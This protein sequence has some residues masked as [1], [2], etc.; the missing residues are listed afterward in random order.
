[1][2]PSNTPDNA[3]T[4]TLDRGKAKYFH[5]REAVLR[6]FMTLCDDAVKTNGGTTFLVDGAPGAGKSALLHECAARAGKEGWVVAQHMTTSAF[7]QA[8]SMRK[9]MHQLR[10][11]NIESG[12]LQ[13]W[14]AETSA[15]ST[16][17]EPI[18]VLG[19]G[20][21][22]LLLVL[23]EAQKLRFLA[24]SLPGRDGR[25][26]LDTIDLIHN[27]GLGRPV[28]LL[29]GGLG[30]TAAAFSSLGISRVDVDCD[31]TLGPLE[32][33]AERA[34]LHDWFTLGA[35]AQGD[36]HVW[37]EAIMRE[38]HGWPQHTIVYIKSALRYLAAHGRSITPDGLEYVL[39]G[40]R[41]RRNAYY[42]GRTDSFNEIEL[43]ALIRSFP[44]GDIGSTITYR[45]IMAAL[46]EAFSVQE[47][48]RLYWR[49]RDK[50][51]LSKHGRGYVIP[52][53][54]MHAWL[55]RRYRGA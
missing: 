15:V 4:H 30:T 50:G 38:T 44:E 54:S 36:P 51:V 2:V 26:A 39:H 6:E 49:A 35:K 24:D 1:M 52:I 8:S 28:I 37:I 10:R 46:Q 19:Q 9:R 3:I 43:Q 14:V 45:D 13:L 5:G 32:P 17:T 7:Y 25:L 22:P 20:D 31:Y 27:G 53:P 42:L 34:I 18:D 21:E 48:E 12:K 11:Y 41:E 29:A 40:G 33:D 23:D 47:A 16:L 55:E